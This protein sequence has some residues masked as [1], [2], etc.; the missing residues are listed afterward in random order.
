MWQRFTEKARQIV[1]RAQEQAGQFGTP[2][3][4]PE[5]LLLGM[6]FVEGNMGLRIL[7]SLGFPSQEI[8]DEIEA[9]LPHDV[10]TMGED[11]ALTPRSKKVV[12]FAYVA[13]KEL[14]HDHIGGEHLLLGILSEGESTAAAT[15]T[16]HEITPGRVKE[17]LRQLQDRDLRTMAEAKPNEELLTLEEAVQFLNTS[18]PTLYRVLGQGDLKGLKVGRQWRFRKVDLVAYMERSPVAVAAAPAPDLNAALELL[19]EQ[20]PQG[21]PVAPA[22]AIP[23]EEDPESKTIR[24]SHKIIASAIAMHA[25]DIHLEPTR[26]E[27]V[28]FLRLRYRVDGVLQEIQRMPESLQ[29]SLTTRF[30]IMA[31]MNTNEKRVPQD[32]RIPV[33][34][35]N[36]DFDIRVSIV[37]SIFGETIAMRILDKSTALIGLDKLGLAADDLLQVRDLLHQPNGLVIATGPTGSGKTT[38]LYNCLHEIA[39]IEKKV[40]TIEDPVE[41]QMPYMTQVVVNKRNGVTFANALRSFLRQD[42]DIILVGETRDIETAQLAVE[43][44]LTGHLVLTTLHTND[45]P[46]AL[47]RLLEMGLES[48]LIAA[49]VTGIVAQ[50]LCRKIC[51]DCKETYQIP[52]RELMRF[53]LEPDDPEQTITLSRGKGCEKCRNRGYRGRTGLF[54]LLV[55]NDALADLIVGHASPTEIAAAARAAGMN[56]L[57]QDGLLKVLDGIT[58]PDEVLRVCMAI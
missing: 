3:V 52:A 50:R 28:N 13:A 19:T 51:D 38:L 35:G 41:F 37:P 26:E 24:L 8:R 46:S 25:S 18:K 49:T 47:T 53:G 58:T 16:K 30:K 23:M 14:K 56:S 6:T 55:M 34:H 36:K 1:F 20:T 15:L 42:P 5:H 45:A 39:D 57:W 21:Q 29:E 4:T 54:E 31:D 11:L 7:E 40:I 9:Q 43:A 10:G 33:R 12:D 48:Y 44:S 27:G 22:E 32:G 2:Y 17:Q